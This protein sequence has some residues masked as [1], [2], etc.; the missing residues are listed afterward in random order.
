[1]SVWYFRAR[2]YELVHGTIFSDGRSH[3]ISIYKKVLQFNPLA[4]DSRLELARL[5]KE[6]GEVRQASAVL[7]EGLRWPRPKGQKDIDL[8]VSAAQL[9][10]KTGNRA[11][12]DTLMKEARKRAGKYKLL[13]QKQH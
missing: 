9:R 5:Y 12:H 3:A 10:L 7:E 1:M 8:L 13:Y 4:V 6:D 11:G 2:L